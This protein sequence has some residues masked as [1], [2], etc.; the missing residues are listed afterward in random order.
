MGS[1]A[2]AVEVQD[3]LV[4]ELLQQGELEVRAELQH[5]Q[6]QQ[7]AN[8]Q[9]GIP[10]LFSPSS[11]SSPSN[12]CSSNGYTTN[13]LV[14]PRCNIQ[15]H[16]DT[17]DL[18]QQHDPIEM[19]QPQQLQQQQHQQQQHQH[20]QHFQH[21]RHSQ[22]LFNQQR[23]SDHLH[24]FL[25]PESLGAENPIVASLPLITGRL[26][27][28]AVCREANQAV[29]RFAKESAVRLREKMRSGRFDLELSCASGAVEDVWVWAQFQC[30]D[31]EPFQVAQLALFALGGHQRRLYR[32]LH[33]REPPNAPPLL[34]PGIE[35][36]DALNAASR[37]DIRTVLMLLASGLN[38]NSGYTFG[39]TLLMSAVTG[40]QPRMV[41]VLLACGAKP[42]SVDSSGKRA[43]DLAR[44]H[45]RTEIC[46]ILT[47]C[48]V[49]SETRAL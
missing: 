22:S 30:A 7:Y 2:S 11:P 31:Y 40:N 23:S 5:K 8:S 35:R 21:Q 19:K 46:D 18:K 43:V 25:A 10:E 17:E 37:G 4:P 41:E 49:S 13:F 24:L 27:F 6:Q 39:W 14:S 29:Q 26:A 44:L 47:R 36:T 3:S 12:I 34:D 32:L 1:G 28:Q 33:S 20:F 16:T 9:Y 38:V 42:E 45:D 48:Q 15:H